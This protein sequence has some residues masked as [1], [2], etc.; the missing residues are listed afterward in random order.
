MSFFYSASKINNGQGN[1]FFYLSDMKI[2][3]STSLEFQ[4]MDM[5]TIG[6]RIFR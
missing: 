6:E 1:H 3:V 4:V 2:G 5:P